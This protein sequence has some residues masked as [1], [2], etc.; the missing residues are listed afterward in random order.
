[1]DFELWSWKFEK[2]MASMS[3]SSNEELAFSS[4]SFSR[5]V[6]S[7]YKLAKQV[8]Y[9]RFLADQT[10]SSLAWDHC[11]ERGKDNRSSFSDLQYKTERKRAMQS[12]DVKCCPVYRRGY[13]AK[14]KTEIENLK[15]KIEYRTKLSI[16]GR[17]PRTQKTEKHD[18]IVFSESE[19]EHLIY[20]RQVFQA[21]FN[22]GFIV[23]RDKS[24]FS[25]DDIKYLGY[26][27]SKDG[28]KVNPDRVKAIV[29]YSTYA[30]TK[31]I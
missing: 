15:L 16:R 10:Q 23:K 27:F 21:L 9:S 1:M 26:V 18:I 13:H 12:Q 30:T 20:L 24:R 11:E 29:D 8:L 22:S 4:S 28:M 5:G 2:C 25:P 6:P 19:E 17:C 3:K 31:Q 14:P 7:S